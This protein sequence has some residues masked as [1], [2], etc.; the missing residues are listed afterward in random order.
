MNNKPN[1]YKKYSQN[2]G[3]YTTLIKY[4][5]KASIVIQLGQGSDSGGI[6]CGKIN[7]GKAS[8]HQIKSSNITITPSSNESNMIAM[9]KT[10]KE[11]LA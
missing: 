9:I 10:E 7:K 3:F 4:M 5:V 8:R 6:P 11:W 2:F 1:N